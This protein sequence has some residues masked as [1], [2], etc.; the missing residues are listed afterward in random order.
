MG[1]NTISLAPGSRVRCGDADWVILEV[2]A[3]ERV[4]ARRVADGRREFLTVYDLTPSTE[5]RDELPYW[6]ARVANRIVR[7]IDLDSLE[8]GVTLRNDLERA[9]TEFQE[10]KRVLQATTAGERA[11]LL[12][13]YANTYNYSV[14]AAYRRL[15]IVRQSDSADAL[16]RSVRSDKGNLRLSPEALEIMDRRLAELRFVATPRSV[17]DILD[18][19]NGDLRRLGHKE[20]S[21]SSLYHRMRKTPRLK[22]MLKAGRLEEAKN[23]YRAKVGHLP[24]ASYPLSIVQVDHTPCQICFVDERH[25][26]PIGDAWLT[27]V[28]DCFSRM[29]LGF[30]LSFDAPSTLNTGLALA[31]AFLPKQNFLRAL[32]VKG[33]WP[34]WGFP[35]VI[36]VDN[37]AELNGH[38]M[39]GARRR[40]RFDLR[41]RPLG[42]PNFGGHVES[43][44]K[45]FMYEH[46]SVPGTKFSNPKERAEYDSEG[47]AVMTLDAFEKLFAEF[48]VNDY[49]L[50]EHSGEGMDRRAPI[51]RWTDGV[52]HG[53]VMP[54]TGL[55]DIPSDPE[56]LRISLMPVEWRALK[57]ARI[58]IFNEEYYSGALALISDKVDVKKPLEQRKFEVRYDPRDISKIWVLD[59]ATGSYI[60]ASRTSLGQLPMSLWE[61]RARRRSLGKPDK[62]FDEVRYQSKLE[63]ERIKQSET[64]KTKQARKEAERERRNRI[65]SLVQP[66]RVVKKPSSTVVPRKA[67]DAEKLAAL[68]SKVR[69]ASVDGSDTDVSGEDLS[70]SP[71][72]GGQG[73][74]LE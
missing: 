35:D 3:L 70:S 1:T 71:S 36:L 12:R 40:Y 26:L 23:L 67:L 46:K 74:V 43:A 61:H 60:E 7:R 19:V 2:E 11:E 6:R 52:R 47:Q 34:C 58:E 44:F 13:Q 66:V 30:Y 18:F 27:L 8:K 45:T 17:E 9:T 15:A 38:M 21:R 14:P 69:A 37:A 62:V 22:Q 72:N 49:H 56:Q 59:P 73:R 20:I 64:K 10:L 29:V 53:D 68:R 25:R 57:N 31:R 24:D 48:L 55:P 16:L 65:D 4:L 28:I 51:Q 32:E 33:E 54:P 63:R 41:D 50:K 5:E 39:H 42:Q